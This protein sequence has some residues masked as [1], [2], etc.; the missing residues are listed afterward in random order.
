VTLSENLEFLGEQSFSACH[1]LKEITIPKKVNFIASDA[2]NNM[3]RLEKILVD[4]DNQSF[5]SI[6]GLLLNKS[7]TTL[8]RFPPRKGGLDSDYKIPTCVTE[9]GKHAFNNVCLNKVTFNK[10]LAITKISEHAFSYSYIKEIAI[11]NSVQIIESKAF[12]NSYELNKLSL[13]V[14][15]SSLTTISNFAF[16]NCSKL[17]N[18]NFP[19][20][21][22]VIENNAF[23]GCTYLSRLTLP[24]SLEIIGDYAFK[25]IGYVRIIFIA[26]TVT[27][28]A[29]NAFL[30]TNIY[31]PIYI[32]SD[33]IIAQ[34]S[35]TAFNGLIKNKNIY[36]PDNYQGELPEYIKEN[37]TKDNNAGIKYYNEI[38]FQYYKVKI[39]WNENFYCLIR[40]YIVKI[41]Q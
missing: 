5:M 24:K 1:N 35:E 10:D 19:E 23:E 25:N 22:K 3:S 36:L 37:Y 20:N 12:Y 13:N 32:A 9:I 15:E 6:D 16:A 29:E 4:A 2:F 26:R 7:G 33:I 21:L 38:W 39:K 8:Y 28:L 34:L 31:G 27:N 30:G 18:I 17:N 40:L 11:P 41:R 14:I